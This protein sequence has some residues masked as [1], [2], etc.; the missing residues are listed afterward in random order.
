MGHASGWSVIGE[1]E[2]S[3]DSPAIAD[4]DLDNRQAVLPSVMSPAC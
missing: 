2:M 3:V 1:Q 4:L